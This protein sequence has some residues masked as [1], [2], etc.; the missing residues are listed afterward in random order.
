M[1]GG[2]LN[3]IACV[4][5]G[6]ADRREAEA[7]EVQADAA[8]AVT[9]LGQPRRGGCHGSRWWGSNPCLP[10]NPKSQPQLVAAPYVVRFEVAC[11]P[12]TRFKCTE[13]FLVTPSS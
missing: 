6:L 3:C 7:M 8:G 1:T 4:S 2:G 5:A 11:L 9:R 10:A 13:P 12:S